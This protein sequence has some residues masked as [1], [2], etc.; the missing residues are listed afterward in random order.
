MI[1]QDSIKNFIWESAKET[2]ETMIFL[3]IEQADGQSDPSKF[4]S[5]ICTITFTGPLQGFFSILCCTEGVEKIARA[6]S[7]TEPND[8]IEESDICDA[9]GEVTNMVIGGIKSRMNEAAPDIKISIPTVTTGMEI[10]PIFSKGMTRINIAT[11][12]DGHAMEMAL[13]YK[14]VS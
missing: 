6:M 10:R 11:K 9:W 4:P 14:T 5:L 2:F 8:S 3:P 7:M 12:A 13:M 1:E